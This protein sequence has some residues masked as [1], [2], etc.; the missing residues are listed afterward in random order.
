VGPPARAVGSG[1]S[2]SPPSPNRPKYGLNLGCASVHLGP[3][4]QKPARYLGQSKRRTWRK[5]QLGPRRQ[6]PRLWGRD[7]RR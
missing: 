2:S 7:R 3:S 4:G 1:S 6:K 5:R